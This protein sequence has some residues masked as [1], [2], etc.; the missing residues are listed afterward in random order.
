MA[1]TSSNSMVSISSTISTELRTGCILQE[2]LT[3]Y[4]LNAV[5][6]WSPFYGTHMLRGEGP[7]TA[8][9]AIRNSEWTKVIGQCWKIPH[10]NRINFCFRTGMSGPESVLRVQKFL[11]HFHKPAPNAQ[12]GEFLNVWDWFDTGLS[13]YWYPGK[14]A[15]TMPLR[16]PNW[17]AESNSKMSNSFPL[18]TMVAPWRRVM[19]I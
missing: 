7:E 8:E 14:Q 5:P 4:N 2:A 13:A 6:G 15:S 1:S 9:D 12:R 16:F 10:D 18:S 11:S 3:R 17:L 19:Y